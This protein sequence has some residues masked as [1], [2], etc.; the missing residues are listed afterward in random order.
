VTDLEPVRA[1]TGLRVLRCGGSGLY[2]GELFDLRPLRGMALT[3]LDCRESLVFDLTPLVDMPLVELKC[4]RTLVTDLT[5]L[6][7]LKQLR[8]LTC[9]FR[10][11]RDAA[12]LHSVETLERINDKPAAVFWAEVG[13]IKRSDVVRQGAV[14]LGLAG[15]WREAADRL[16]EEPQADGHYHFERAALL[17]LAGDA[18]GHN[19]AVAAMR[20]RLEVGGGSSYFRTYHLAR[21]ATLHPE[22][23]VA[24]AAAL[25][26]EELD[27]N[28]GEP[29]ALTLRGAILVR[30]GKPADG[31][32]YLER[33][34]AADSR[35][36]RAVLNHLWLAL[37]E[38][39]RG[40]KEKARSGWARR[41]TTRRL[42]DVARRWPRTGGWATTGSGLRPAREIEAALAAAESARGGKPVNGGAARASLQR[43]KSAMTSTCSGGGNPVHP[44]PRH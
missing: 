29:W 17:L 26:K 8:V 10:L 40:D 30:Q 36:G 32:K 9:D 15:K 5:P 18:E 20:R 39:R 23:D 35:P 12:I 7:R 6:K 37:A 44:P 43:R 38:L 27:A 16:P 31:I 28:A 4:D 34:L 1:L 2:R 14:G 13:G 21:A 24:A 42:E 19:K 11:V 25:A 33:S 22:G 3:H 41:P